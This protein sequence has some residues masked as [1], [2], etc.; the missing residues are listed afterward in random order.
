MNMDL[1]RLGKFLSSVSFAAV[2]AACLPDAVQAQNTWTG[3][4]DS[5]WSNPDN[6]SDGVVPDYTT[7]VVINGAG[8]PPRAMQPIGAYAQSVTV[9]DADGAGELEISGQGWLEM[10]GDLVISDPG[11]GNAGTVSIVGSMGFLN[12]QGELMIN[13][14]NNSVSVLEIVDSPIV[15]VHGTTT[16]GDGAILVFQGVDGGDLIGEGGIVVEGMLLFDQANGTVHL[17]KDISGSGEIKVSSGAGSAVLGGDNSAF[18]GTY[19]VTAGLL[20]TGSANGLGGL[21]GMAALEMTDGTVLLH[22]ATQFAGLSGTGGTVDTDLA[23]LV[24]NQDSDTE[25]AGNIVGT[26]G[27]VKLGSGR[28]R[29]SGTNDFDYTSQVLEGTLELDGGQALGDATNVAVEE[30]AQLVVL[31]DETI[32]GLALYGGTL[33]VADTETL[34]AGL[35][36]LHDGTVEGGA[37]EADVFDLE[38]GEVNSVLTGSGA[39]AKSSSNTVVLNGQNDF[40]GGT[41]VSEGE[42]VVNGAIGD[43]VVEGGTLS[44]TGS[45]GAMTVA[46]GATVAPGASIG[47]LSAGGDIVFESGSLY[48]VEIGAAGE[49][50]LLST[51][52]AVTLDGGVVSVTALADFEVG[53]SYQILHADGGGSGEFDGVTGDVESLFLAAELGYDVNDVFLEVIQAQDFADVALTPNQAAAA[54]GADSLGPGSPVWDAIVV[55][56]DEADA[57]AAFDALSGEIHASMQ[58]ALLEDGLRILD[59]TQERLRAAT[60]SGDSGASGQVVTGT[61]GGLSFWG[62]GLGSWRELDGDGNAGSLDLSLGGF[63]MGADTLAWND[64]RVGVMGSAAH[65]DVDADDR[66]LVGL[67]GHLHAGGLRGAEPEGLRRFGRRGACLARHRH[68]ARGVVPGV[69]RSARCLL[70][71][72]DAASLGRGFPRIRYRGRAAGALRRPCLRTAFHGRLR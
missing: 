4:S 21:D 39:L 58:T 8:Q 30:G 68:F 72:K 16:I 50:D 46:S 44:G 26:G 61:P 17:E 15:A 57:T 29:L 31:S 56:D 36:Y 35:V 38:S 2:A 28:L 43:V 63:A 62:Q 10:V 55:L 20:E 45:V 33:L 40:S 49:S 19:S 65:S 6:W 1:G 42:L 22:E 67:G 11:G 66:G 18:T 27:I 32:G 71:G 24:V 34:K 41:T 48:E 53:T 14:D 37:V 7:V 51:T 52:G 59:A 9:G 69:L 5:D 60:G 13:G 23:M 3:A 70:F 64:W 12:V 25:F 54:G 47:T